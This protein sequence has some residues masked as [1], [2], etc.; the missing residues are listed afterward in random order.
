M[1]YSKFKVFPRI[2]HNQNYSELNYFPNTSKVLSPLVNI[3]T[4]LRNMLTV[5]VLSEELV[6]KKSSYVSPLLFS[7]KELLTQRSLNHK[8]KEGTIAL[9]RT[10]AEY[11]P[12]EVYSREG[13]G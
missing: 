13:D 4:Y 12:P 8:E 6:K 5:C 1:N 3:S 2:I 10:V 9:P 7:E 11:E